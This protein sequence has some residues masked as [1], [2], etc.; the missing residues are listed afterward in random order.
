LEVGTLNSDISRVR[1]SLD[2]ND[3]LRQRILNK[4]INDKITEEQK[5]TVM[6]GADAERLMLEM[7]L[8]DLGKKQQLSEAHIDYALN[9]MTD[10]SK[11]WHEAPLDVK[12]AFQELVFPQGFEYHIKDRNFITPDISPLY[13]LDAGVSGA[14]NDKNF[15]LV[16]PRRI[17]LRLPG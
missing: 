10:I 14:M 8:D 15:A 13:S 2:A 12:Q 17:E 7:K 6:C 4:F 3:A 16:I 1:T 11:R 5:L 9:F